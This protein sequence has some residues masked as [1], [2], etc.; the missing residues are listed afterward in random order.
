MCPPSPENINIGAESQDILGVAA[1]GVQTVVVQSEGVGNTQ[2]PSC[3]N[4]PNPSSKR[5]WSQNKR[6]VGRLQTVI[7][8]RRFYLRCT[9]IKQINIVMNPRHGIYIDYLSLLCRSFTSQYF[10]MLCLITPR[11]APYAIH[12]T[13]HIISCLRTYAVFFH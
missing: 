2:T 5:R 7:D 1:G 11:L 12:Y 9:A 10:N 3:T 8:G 4:Y 6:S 13:Q